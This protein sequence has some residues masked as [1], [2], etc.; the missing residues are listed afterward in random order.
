MTRSDVVSVEDQLLLQAFGQRLRQHRRAK[1]L[2]T[3]DLAARAGI[4]RNTLRCVEQGD[5][6][7]AIGTYLRVVSV[8][9]LEVNLSLKDV[10]AGG[11]RPAEEEP[12]ALPVVAEASGHFMQDVQSLALHREAV[13]RVKSDATLIARAQD[14]LAGW[15]AAGPSSTEALWLEWQDILASRTWRRVLAMTGR[16]QQLRQASPLLTVLHPEARQAILAQ[17]AEL[18]R[19]SSGN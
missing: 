8:L 5:P 9:C 12:Q 2:G 13:L 14:V 1:R 15:L 10:S 17:V 7:T 4:S 16:A 11:G 19:S 18:K 6:G 3:V